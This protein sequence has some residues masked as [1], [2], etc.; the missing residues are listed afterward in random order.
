M[1]RCLL[2]KWNFSADRFD[3]EFDPFY[4]PFKPFF[5]RLRTGFIFP[6][7][8]TGVCLAAYIPLSKT[9]F[10]YDFLIFR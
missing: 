6:H 3:D 7:R 10:W 8:E 9:S 5:I 2:Q 1:H 4:L